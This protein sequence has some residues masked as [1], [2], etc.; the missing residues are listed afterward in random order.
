MKRKEHLCWLLGFG[1]IF[2]IEIYFFWTLSNL[3]SNKNTEQTR[4]ENKSHG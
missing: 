3:E 2:G 1:I 4:C